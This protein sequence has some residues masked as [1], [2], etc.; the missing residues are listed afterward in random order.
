MQTEKTGIENGRFKYILF[1]CMETLVDL[2]Q[3]PALRDYA[4]WGY[5]GSGV[6]ALWKGFEDFF[7]YYNIAR[8]DLAGQLAEHQEYEMRERFL[9]I[10]RISCP[11]M[12]MEKANEAAD[13]LYS[14]YWVNYRSRCYVK[15]D[16]REVLPR[17]AERFRLGVVSNFMVL[18]GIEELLKTHGILDH[19]DFVVTSVKE[20]WR[21]PHPAIYSAA[22]AQWGT[23]PEETVFVGDDYINDY[24]TPAGLGMCPVFLDRYDRHPEIAHRVRDFYELRDRLFR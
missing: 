4:A 9:R 16:I 21:K 1:D 15:E 10:I 13:R 18:E 14:N 19:F 5:E 12:G 23:K 22:L 2:T 8:G 11:C 24:V 17:L 6:E 3:L 7:L 20:G